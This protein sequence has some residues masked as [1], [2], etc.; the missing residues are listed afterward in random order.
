MLFRSPRRPLISHLPREFPISLDARYQ[1]IDGSSPPSQ[2][3]GRTVWLSS[4][5]VVLVVDRDLPSG[6]PL[7]ITIG[8][9]AALDQRIS[10]QLWI[11]ADVVHTRS[12][13]VTA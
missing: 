6:L 3:N 12:Q 10:L 8:W 1:V 4:R 5:E 13:G 7:E 2:G 11:R 9:P